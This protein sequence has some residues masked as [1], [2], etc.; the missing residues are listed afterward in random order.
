MSFRRIRLMRHHDPAD[1]EQGRAQDLL[2]EL[3]MQAWCEFHLGWGVGGAYKRKPT[4]ERG[5]P[6]GL[7][8]SL[9]PE[10]REL[11]TK[12]V[13]NADFKIHPAFA[14]KDPNVLDVLDPH[15]S[16]W[17]LGPFLE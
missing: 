9:S 17:K 4:G 14:E 16:V 3:A 12:L 1:S 15:V 5:K 2:D 6:G 10:K 13:S 8:A 11:L 7:I